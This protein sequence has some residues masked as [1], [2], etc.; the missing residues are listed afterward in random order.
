MTASSADPGAYGS[1]TWKSSELLYEV[2]A[3][4]HDVRVGAAE[5]DEMHQALID[6]LVP[7]ADN[8]VAEIRAARLATQQARRGALSE[9]IDLIEKA[10][11]STNSGMLRWAANALRELRGGE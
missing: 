10:T 7:T 6:R 2:A 5:F 3:W 1:D 4:L 9:A 11:P 8:A